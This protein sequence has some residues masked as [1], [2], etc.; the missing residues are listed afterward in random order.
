MNNLSS[1]IPWWE[2]LFNLIWIFGA[3]LILAAISYHEFMAYINKIKRID[4]FKGISFRKSFVWGMILVSTG[5]GASINQPYL[6]GIAWSVTIF[7]MILLFILL[8]KQ[9]SLR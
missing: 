1:S 8:K 3:S 4:A 2:I 6:M 5:V 9:V 7:L